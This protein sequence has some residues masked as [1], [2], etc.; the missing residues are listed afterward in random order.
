MVFFA[1]PGGK[2]S[3]SFEQQNA[4][5]NHLGSRNLGVDA[6]LKAIKTG[7][8]WQTI[9]EDSSGREFRNIRDGLWGF[10]IHSKDKDR[11]I[12]GFVYEFI[13]TTDQSGRYN[14]YWSLNGIKYPYPVSGGIQHWVGGDDDYFNNGLYRFGWTYH[15]M[16]IGTPLITSP[17]ALKVNDNAGK[18]IWNNKVICHHIGLEGRYRYLQYIIFATWSLNYGTN[19]FPFDPALKQYSFLLQTQVVDKLPWGISAILAFGIDHGELYGNN[20][21]FKLSLIKKGSF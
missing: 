2:N 13:H 17:A 21:G 16:V 11:L 7:I 10:Y 19:S 14:T 15:N 5:G 3:T 1:D 12:N 9:I 18:Y 8:Y 4:L 20:A 6:D